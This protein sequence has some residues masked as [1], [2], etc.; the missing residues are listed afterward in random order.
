MTYKRQTAWATAGMPALKVKISSGTVACMA[1]IKGKDLWVHNLGDCRAGLC[2]GGTKAHAVSKDH[3]AEKNAADEAER[4]RPLWV[5]VHGG[6]VGYHVAVS[7]AF[8]NIEYANGKKTPARSTPWKRSSPWKR[9]SP[10]KRTLALAKKYGKNDCRPPPE[11]ASSSLGR[12]RPGQTSGKC[13]RVAGG[14]DLKPCKS[15][16]TTKTAQRPWR[17]LTCLEKGARKPGRTKQTRAEKPPP[18]TCLQSST[19]KGEKL[20][21]IADVSAEQSCQHACLILIISFQ[22]FLVFSEEQLGFLQD[23]NLGACCFAHWVLYAL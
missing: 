18:G 2:T 13:L 8:G 21:L 5:Q 16:A 12:K 1:L 15:P 17:R 19:E 11:A 9:N 3:A 4:L 22:V 20:R 7:R 23:A 6:Y 14:H 10:W